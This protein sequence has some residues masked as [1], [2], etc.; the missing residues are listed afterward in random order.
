M[1]YVDITKDH[2]I[3]YEYIPGEKAP[4]FLYLH[5]FMSQHD[6]PKARA[7]KQAVLSQGWGYLA[8]DYTGHGQ[9]SGK[10]TD[11]RIGRCLE[12]TKAVLETALSDQPFVVCGSSLGGWVSLLI[13]L[14]YKERVKGVI[15]LAPGVDFTQRVWDNY[16]PQSVKERLKNGEVFGPTPQTGN[17]CWTYGLFEEAKKHLLKPKG[18]LDITCPVLLIQGDIDKS[19]PW[20]ETIALKDQMASEDITLVLVKNME[21]TLKTEKEICILCDA[22][23]SL[24][25]KVEKSCVLTV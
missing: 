17:Y 24:L 14:Q 7:L 11:I 18:T 6:T 8:L 23:L 22:T 2:H 25:R 1:P 12:D 15:G 13:A 19:V 9:S 21:H 20:Q 10:I 3:Y 16:F 5:G 4:V